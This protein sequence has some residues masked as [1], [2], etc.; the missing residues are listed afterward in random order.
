[1][2]LVCVTV[3]QYG[4]AVVINL[5]FY[6]IATFLADRTLVT[7]ELLSWLSSICPFVCSS[8]MYCG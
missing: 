5:L 2:L 7:V 8:W 6:F 1:V 3:D 4:S